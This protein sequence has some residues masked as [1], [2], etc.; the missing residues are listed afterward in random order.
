VASEEKCSVACTAKRK[1]GWALNVPRKKLAERLFIDR[2]KQ[3]VL[4]NVNEMSRNV[5]MAIIDQTIDIIGCV[6]EIQ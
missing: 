5:V 6:S 4:I 3:M 2:S 1:S